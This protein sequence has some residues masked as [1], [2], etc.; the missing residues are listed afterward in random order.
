MNGLQFLIKCV[1]IYFNCDIN[2]FSW[3]G[4]DEE[5]SYLEIFE[6][7]FDHSDTI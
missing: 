7:L 2:K 6:A 3:D 1:L 4:A 5:M